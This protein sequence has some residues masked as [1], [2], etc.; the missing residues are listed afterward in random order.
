[1]IRTLF[2]A[3]CSVAFFAP[4]T[5]AQE[6]HAI[7]G[8][9]FQVFLNQKQGEEETIR[10]DMA[11]EAVETVVKAFGILVRDRSQYKRFDQAI[12]NDLLQNV[13][14]EPR[15]LNKEG[16]EFP[17]L[18]ARTKQKGKVNLLINAMRLR[19]DGYLGQP[20]TLAPRLAKEFQW[21]ISKA[22]TKSA[23]RGRLLKRDLLR[24][25]VSTNA[26]IRKM[27]PEERTEVLQ[28]LLDTYIQTVDAYGSLVDQPYY[29]MGTT[30]L[31]KPEH[32][33]STIKLYDIRV[34]HALRLI[35][36]D[37]YF[38]DNTQKAVRSLL[39]GKVWHVLM[40]KIDERDWTARTRVVPEDKAVTVGK[41]G[42]V[43]QP[44]KVLVNYHRTVE[45]KEK[46]Y[47]ETQGLPMGALSAEQ[48]A[49]VIAWEIQSQ[50]TEKSLRG[51]VA[52]DEQTAPE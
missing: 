19:E 39:N 40:A 31:M 50:V 18:V 4:A 6:G 13:V 30:T 41:R 34:R 36:S 49:R 14:I 42:R 46:L 9:S 51:H 25:R 5:P 37:P 17:F 33:D 45:P 3:L 43:I 47:G 32:S 44:A 7:P 8:V 11:N 16:K 28:A 27:A 12:T 26:E 20:D 29:E 1:M 52:Q 21:V 15:V 10:Q 2:L 24:A 23:R 35:V 38:W 22:A 48:L